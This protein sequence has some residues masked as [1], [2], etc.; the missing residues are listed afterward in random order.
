M[1]V[2]LPSS[3]GSAYTGRARM[4]WLPLKKGLKCSLAVV[5][6]TAALTLGCSPEP[7]VLRE[8][9]MRLMLIHDGRYAVEAS[10]EG[11]TTK[12]SRLPERMRKE[13]VTFADWL[14]E[15]R[16]LDDLPLDLAKEPSRAQ[17]CYILLFVGGVDAAVLEKVNAFIREAGHVAVN[18]EGN[19]PPFWTEQD[20]P[21]KR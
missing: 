11:N 8:G 21:Q 1:I 17:I 10:D 9:A 14:A 15:S 3:C 18:V 5:V 6:T 7:H 13:D 12:T 20:Q 4:F 19:L 2:S 16:P